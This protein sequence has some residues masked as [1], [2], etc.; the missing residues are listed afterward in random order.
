MSVT[1]HFLRIQTKLEQ[2]RIHSMMISTP[3]PG[4]QRGELAASGAQIDQLNVEHFCFRY[5]GYQLHPTLTIGA[6]EAP[7]LY[8]KLLLRQASAPADGA[9]PPPQCDPKLDLPDSPQN[10]PKSANSAEIQER[11]K[12]FS[13]EGL[14]EKTKKTLRNM[15]QERTKQKLR[16]FFEWK[17]E[18]H[19]VLFISGQGTQDAALVLDSQLEATLGLGDILAIWDEVRKSE[20]SLVRQSPAAAMHLL[21][22]VDTCFAGRWS[23]RL[24]DLTVTRVENDISVQTAPTKGPRVDDATGESIFLSNFLN[25]NG[26]KDIRYNKQYQEDGV[27]SKKKTR[28][29]AYYSRRSDVDK[30]YDLCVGF[31]RWEEMEWR[32]SETIQGTFISETKEVFTGQFKSI[33]LNGLGEKKLANGRVERGTFRDNKLDGEGVLEWN[34]VRCH[35]LFKAG[36]LVQPYHVNFSNGEYVDFR[37]QPE[38]LASLA[39]TLAAADDM[40][41]EIARFHN[42]KDDVHRYERIRTMFMNSDVME[43]SYRDGQKHGVNFHFKN[44]GGFVFSH[45]EEGKQVYRYAVAGD[46]TM[47]LSFK[48][49]LGDF[50]VRAKAQDKPEESQAQRSRQT[51]HYQGQVKPIS[52]DLEQLDWS[53]FGVDGRQLRYNDMVYQGDWSEERGLQVNGRGRLNFGNGGSYEGQW[54]NGRPQGK[55]TLRMPEGLVYEGGWRAGLRHGTGRTTYPDG[56]SY[57][58]EWRMD[59]IFGNGDFTFHDRVISGLLFKPECLNTLEPEDL[60]NDDQPFSK[61]KPER[62]SGFVSIR[63]AASATSFNLKVFA[64]RFL[65]KIENA[66]VYSSRKWCDELSDKK[67]EHVRM[68]D[69]GVFEGELMGFGRLAISDDITFVGEFINNCLW[70][71]GFAKVTKPMQSVEGLY[72]GDCLLVLRDKP[73]AGEGL[74]PNALEAWWEPVFFHGTGVLRSLKTGVSPAGSDT[75]IDSPVFRKSC[76]EVYEGEFR[77]GEYCGRGRREMELGD[78]FEGQFK[79][80][81]VDCEGNLHLV[82]KAFAE[83]KV[84]QGKFFILRRGSVAV[85]CFYITRADSL[86]LTPTL[87]YSGEVRYRRNHLNK[88]NDPLDLDEHWKFYDLHGSGV[89]RWATG[90][91]L[92]G[93]FRNSKIDGSCLFTNAAGVEIKGHFRSDIIITSDKFGFA[94]IEFSVSDALVGLWNGSCYKGDAVYQLKGDKSEDSD[95][96]YRELGRFVR[97]RGYGAFRNKRGETFVGRWDDKGDFKGRYEM[98]GGRTV[99]GKLTRRGLEVP[100]VILRL[101]E[102]IIFRGG[103][104]YEWRESGEALGELDLNEHW[105]FGAL[106]GEAAI[107]HP[108]K[109]VFK[110]TFEKGVPVGQAFAR[111]WLHHTQDSNQLTFNRSMQEFKKEDKLDIPDIGTYTGMLAGRLRQPLRPSPNPDHFWELDP[112]TPHGCG[113]IT[114]LNGERIVGPFYCG[115]RVSKVVKL[116]CGNGVIYTGECLV[117]V[118][119]PDQIDSPTKLGAKLPYEY[120]HGPGTELRAEGV[121]VVSEWCLGRRV[122]RCKLE[123]PE[124]KGNWDAEFDDNS[125]LLQLKIKDFGKIDQLKIELRHLTVDGRIKFTNKISVEKRTFMECACYFVYRPEGGELMLSAETEVGKFMNETC[126]AVYNSPLDLDWKGGFKMPKSVVESLDADAKNMAKLAYKKG[127]NWKEKKEEKK[128]KKRVEK[129]VTGDKIVVCKKCEKRAENSMEDIFEQISK[130]KQKAWDENESVVHVAEKNEPKKDQKIQTER[131]AWRERLTVEEIEY[132]ETIMMAVMKKMEGGKKGIKDYEWKEKV[133]VDE[134]TTNTEEKKWE[135]VGVEVEGVSVATKDTQKDGP[136]LVAK[137][138]QMDGPSLA[139][140]D[141]QTTEELA[142]AMAADPTPKVVTESALTQTEAVETRESSVGVEGVSVATKDTQKDGPSLVAK[143]TQMDGPSLATKDTQTTEELAPAMAADP[144]P[145]VVTESALTQTDIADPPKSRSLFSTPLLTSK[146]TSHKPPSQFFKHPTQD[147]EFSLYDTTTIESTPFITPT[148]SIVSSPA[149]F[150]KSTLFEPPFCHTSCQTDTINH[151]DRSTQPEPILS[152]SVHKTVREITLP[153]PIVHSK[154]TQIEPTLLH[155]TAPPSQWSKFINNISRLT[156]RISGS[157]PQTKVLPS[158]AVYTGEFNRDK[159]HGNGTLKLPDGGTFTGEFMVGDIQGNGKLE[160]SDGWVLSGWF[161]RVRTQPDTFWVRSAEGRT[162][163]ILIKF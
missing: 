136:S 120:R 121:R 162:S 111:R 1:E 155:K 41:Q 30:L 80:G 127:E 72:S 62:L 47:E 78:V 58:G 134:K 143:D 67:I 77:F 21:L 144:T 39:K 65:L 158:K 88:R 18:K 15:L 44:D 133:A 110:G 14:D 36:R 89:L 33:Q 84:Y 68:F 129:I 128:T 132:E 3:K 86:Q 79:R 50:D 90:E 117:K 2:S 130:I 101:P 24:E 98:K 99:F 82:S 63:P 45:W 51:L 76:R 87:I 34:E 148:E 154:S 151:S 150:H 22:I 105:R 118:V 139:T 109:G 6:D 37:D 81:D 94:N 119:P 28:H 115:L 83:P 56:T 19:C 64:S 161:A 106:H 57:S 70:I 46:G 12:N 156:S 114:R 9:S 7:K 96:D 59:H 108:T 48:R 5:Q 60:S 163:F 93:S 146:H 16:A 40:V 107:T 74:E 52:L 149:P 102:G 157:A 25:I 113:S 91:R 42:P 112:L 147:S 8:K 126:Q 23:Q 69:G 20:S 55:G 31:T 103:V 124:F 104:L 32:V 43:G 26:F 85:D 71:P 10:S 73:V 125:Q 100:N 17:P 27:T 159:F 49:W 131:A 95:L 4:Q 66:S 29:P 38:P 97:I 54:H 61:R 11:L 13:A 35:G 116:N 153:L 53:K 137:D 160:T 152:S 141:T 135:E 123:K 140:K 122:D 138:T 75:Q 145:K 92:E 142:P